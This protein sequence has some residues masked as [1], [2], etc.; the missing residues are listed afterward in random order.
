MLKRQ[1]TLALI[2]FFVFITFSS[3]AQIEKSRDDS[4][5]FHIIENGKYGY[6]DNQGMVVIDPQFD[7]ASK[8]SEGFAYVEIN[9]KWG[10]I[11]TATGKIN[12]EPIF[13]TS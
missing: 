12:L 3:N 8:F 5:L 9:R 6:I 7:Y 2:L 13:S 4:G 10:N 11:D 1:N